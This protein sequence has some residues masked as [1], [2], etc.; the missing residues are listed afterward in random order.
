VLV[1]S[2]GNSGWADLAA[3]RLRFGAWLMNLA[4]KVAFYTSPSGKLRLLLHLPHMI[5]LYWR[6]F[7]DR[8]VSVLPKLVLVA[9]LVYFVVPF[10][11]LPDFPLI[12]L[13][14]VDDVVVL[15]MA[16]RVFIGLS[17]RAVVE[18]HVRLID[19]GA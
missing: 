15:V 14:Q 17:P 8:R 10:D 12:G 19:Q 18:E 4:E 1:E 2:A 9:G 6:V 5:K 16:L 7:T 11:L 3:T 13:G